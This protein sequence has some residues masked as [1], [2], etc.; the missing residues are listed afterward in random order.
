M[1]SS[2]FSS[3]FHDEGFLGPIHALPESQAAACLAELDAYASRLDGGVIQGAWR[4]QTHLFLPWVAEIVRNEALLRA[5]RAALGSEDV[6][7][8]FTEWHIKP[9]QSPGHYT[10]HQVPIYLPIS[11]LISIRCRHCIDRSH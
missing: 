9:P 3:S 4:F 10:P 6:L 1:A 8:W 7:A 11:R 5:V 2:P